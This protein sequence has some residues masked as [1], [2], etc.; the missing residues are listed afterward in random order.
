MAKCYVDGNEFEVVV[1]RKFTVKSLPDIV[2]LCLNADDI[3]FEQGRI[4]LIKLKGDSRLVNGK[5]AIGVNRGEVILPDFLLKLL[6]VSI[7]EQLKIQ[8]VHPIK[9]LDPCYVVIKVVAA[10]SRTRYDNQ[11]VDESTPFIP[12]ALEK[13]SETF[14]EANLNLIVTPGESRKMDV[15]M[16]EME[17]MTC[18]ETEYRLIVEI[19]AIKTLE[20]KPRSYEYVS[21]NTQVVCE[22]VKDS[23]ELIK[24]SR[25]ELEKSKSTDYNTYALARIA[26]KGLDKEFEEQHLL[27]EQKKLNALLEV[28]QKV[29]MALK[30]NNVIKDEIKPK[31]LSPTS[32]HDTFGLMKAQMPQSFNDPTE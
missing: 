5:N 22:N 7:G 8:Q 2:E 12:L 11:K 15:M 1:S 26:E 16:K 3:H 30:R 27:K 14:R 10:E 21:T 25:T 31:K 29:T 9:P 18:K 6:G 24:A 28:W 13:I 20:M 4:L 23:V 17:N 19:I 32:V